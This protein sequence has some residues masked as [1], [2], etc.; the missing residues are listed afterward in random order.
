M[1]RTLFEV[2][3]KNRY[4]G[5]TA[6]ATI[7]GITTD[8]AATL[9]RQQS[10]QRAAR[11]VHQRHLVSALIAAGCEVSEHQAAYARKDLP[12]VAAWLAAQGGMHSGLPRNQHIILVHGNHFGTILGD[13]Y[14]CSLTKGMSVRLKDIPKR[15]ARV[16]S[17]LIV[18]ALPATAP[19]VVATRKPD[20]ERS[21]RQKAKAL[22]KLHDIEIEIDGESVI[23]WGFMGLDDKDDPHEGDHYTE[24]WGDAL[25]R[26]ESYVA[27]KL[28]A[29]A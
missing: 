21:L 13:R 22:A 14:L 9:I 29:A 2:S 15:R 23:V 17:W 18:R 1:K 3:G 28:K 4:C 16:S 19:T 26:V 27:L 24:G 5:P 10:G 7:L 8:D 20:P 11:G 6:M 12:T 25:D